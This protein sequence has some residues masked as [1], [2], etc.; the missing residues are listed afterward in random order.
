MKT[1]EHTL[2]KVQSLLETTLNTREL[3]GYRTEDGK[4]TRC[5]ML[6]RSDEQKHLNEGMLPFIRKKD[7]D[8]Y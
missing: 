8:D 5:N 6:L 2:V 7:Y 1:N 4:Y 3:G